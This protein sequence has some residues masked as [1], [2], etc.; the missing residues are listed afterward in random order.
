MT[1]STSRLPTRAF[2]IEAISQRYTRAYHEDMDALGVQRPTVEPRATDHIDAIIRMIEQ[3]I[4]TGHAYLAEDH[5]LF[6]VDSYADY[7][8]LSRR[9]RREM[10][11]GARVEVAPFKKH[12][13]DFVLWK[14][15][16]PDQPGWDSP[17]GRGRP[18]WHIECS[19]MSAAHLG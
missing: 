6:N 2:P 16:T 15:S 1:R 8:K 12:P 14:P 3:L 9:D 11:A 17:W 10:I 7:G 19:A 18:G 4:S 5:I 13:A